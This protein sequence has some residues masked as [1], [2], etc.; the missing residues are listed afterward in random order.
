M[1]SRVSE[2]DKRKLLAAVR[3]TTALAEKRRKAADDASRARREAVE[4]AMDAEIPRSEI[5]DA[6]G[7]H[8]NVL[9]QIT[10]RRP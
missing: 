5:A 6:A 2:G 7:V 1:K 10:K 3:E 4:A 8:R 9:Y